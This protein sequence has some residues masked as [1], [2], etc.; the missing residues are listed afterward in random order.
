M[1]KSNYLSFVLFIA[2]IWLCSHFSR[3][4]V[5]QT[6]PSINS[7]SY[8]F[9]I[10]IESFKVKRKNL[11]TI[12]FAEIGV[13]EKN[14]SNDGIRVEEYQAYTGNRKGDAWCASFVCW[15]LS[16]ADIVNPR[17]GWSPHLFPESKLVWKNG[18]NTNKEPPQQGDI[19]GIW[20]KNKGRIAHCGFVDDWGTSQVITVEGNTNEAGSREGDGVYRKR[21][22]KNSLHAVANW[23]ERKEQAYEI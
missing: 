22:L 17:S 9:T 8:V 2:A 12:Y 21:R 19:F 18:R 5:K 11:Q 23:I 13:R 15:A 20:F 6:A 1:A 4:L 7:K 3:N 14:N 16:K 10:H